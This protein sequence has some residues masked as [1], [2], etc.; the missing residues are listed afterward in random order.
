MGLGRVPV[1]LMTTREIGIFALGTVLAPSELLPL[2]IFEER[3]KELIGDCLAAEEPFLVVYTDEEG[4]RELGCTARVTEVL[5]RFEDG[6]MNILVEGGELLRVV[7][8]TRG[9]PYTT[10]LVEQ[11]EDDLAVG[12]ERDAT[13]SA[14]REFAAASGIELDE[15]ELEV[16]ELPLSYVIM[17]RIDF[18][19]AD[20]QRILELRS[21]RERLAALVELL[22][23][24]LESLKQLE[25]I[26]RRAQTNGKVPHG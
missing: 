24:G 14:Y 4:T 18:P 15:G 17:S 10:G 25:Q 22:R 26:R 3:Y 12:D 6:R 19:A 2:H 7:E 8:V 23:R 1:H 9:R 16:Q 13:L 5:E 11:V 21:E 20:K